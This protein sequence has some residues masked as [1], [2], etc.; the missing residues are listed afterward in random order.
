VEV[1]LPETIE[2]CHQLIGELCL[3]IK[4]MQVEIDELKAQ[5]KQNSPQFESSAVKR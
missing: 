2:E 4:R 5:L 1:K 3:V